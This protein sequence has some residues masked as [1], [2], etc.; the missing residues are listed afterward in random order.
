ML[1]ALFGVVIRC[2]DPFYAGWFFAGEKVFPRTEFVVRGANE[3]ISGNIQW[4]SW[5]YVTSLLRV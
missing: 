4:F 3:E 5:S 1:L 2:Q